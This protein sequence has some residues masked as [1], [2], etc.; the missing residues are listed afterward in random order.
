MKD[1]IGGVRAANSFPPGIEV[2]LVRHVCMRIGDKKQFSWC[3]AFFWVVVGLT[4][5]FGGLGSAGAQAEPPPPE[6][7]PLPQGLDPP[8]TVYPPTQISE[9]AT[10]YYLVCMACHGDRG[11][12]LTDEWRGALDEPDQNCWQS[13]CHASNYPPGGF[14]FPKIVPAVASP[15]MLA[16]FDTAFDLYLYIKNEMPFQAPGSLRDEEYWQL[17]A[18]LLSLNRVDP[19]PLPLTEERAAKIS[20]R[21]SI[22]DPGV[23]DE[24][25]SFWWAVIALPVLLLASLVLWNF[26]RRFPPG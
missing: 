11:Q 2:L 21:P 5:F 7:P 15:G 26:L 19:G 12:G 3:L 16:K 4:L 17:A 6:M 8:P 23:L 22:S 9:G 20:L 14:V 10:V 18:F 24:K 1:T 13:K 25:F